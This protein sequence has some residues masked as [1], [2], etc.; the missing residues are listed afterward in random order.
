M[1]VCTNDLALCHL[2]EDALPLAVSKSG[3]DAEFLLAE[4]V[5]LEHDRVGLTAV[6]ARVLAQ[7]GD[8]EVNA[9]S[10]KRSLAPPGGVDVSLPV[11][12]VVL[13]LVG[14]PTKAALVVALSLC[15]APPGKV[16]EGL[17][18]LAA[19]APSH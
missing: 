17:L 12:R 7:V 1:T 9:F 6:R 5:E 4:M 18:K 14:G 2:V 13:L 19:S 3:G 10:D 15:F 8:Q 16:I 11:G